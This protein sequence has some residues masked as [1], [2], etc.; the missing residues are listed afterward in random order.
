[1]QIGEQ[2]FRNELFGIDLLERY[3]RDLARRHQVGARKGPERLLS[4][5]ADNEKVLREYNEQ[6]LRVEKKRSLTPAAEW[7]LDNSYLIEEQIHM[8]RRHLP[9]GFSRE[10][11]H[12]LYGPSVNRPRVHDLMIELISHVDA[13]VD[14]PHLTS[15][16]AAYQQLTQLKLGELWAIPIMLRLALIENLRRVAVL[17]STARTERDMADTWADRL[18]EVAESEPSKL[19]IVVA[20]M[21]QSELSLSQ[22]FVTEFWRRIQGKSPLLKPALGWIEQ[23]LAEDGQTI[24]HLIQSENQGQAADQVSVGNSIASLRFLDAMDWREFVETLSVVEQT[25]RLDP[26]DVYGDMD[27]ATRD[28]YR[29]TVER[30]ARSS[31]LSEFEV[32]KLAVDLA[33]P[34]MPQSDPRLGHVGYYLVD[35]GVCALERAA[36]MKVPLKSLL[37]RFMRG[38]PLAFYLGSVVAISAVVM[39]WP[40]D[41]L[42]QVGPPGWAVILSIALLAV[43]ASQVAI[44]LVNWFATLV[45]QPRLIPRLDFSDGIPAEHRTMVVVPTMLTHERDI[46]NLLEALEVR[47]L[48]NRDENVYFALLSDL[49]DAPQEHLPGDAELVRQAREGIEALNRK[50]ER[51][52]RNIFYLFHRPR[53]WNAKENIWMGHER[54]RGKLAEFN[55]CLRGGP[56][57]CFCETIGDLSRLPHIRYVITLDTDTQLPRDAARDLVGSMAHPLNRPVYDPARGR[58]VDGYSILQPRV[59]VSLP[60]ASRSR[61]AKLFSGEPGVDPYTRGV[62]DVYQDL[63]HE[64]SFIGKGIYDV[65][66]FEQAVGGRF[67]ENRI[68]S[69]DLLEGSYARSALVTDVQLFEE[70]PGRYTADMHRRHRWMRGDWQIA[71]WLLPRVPGPDAR[72]VANPITGLSRW[73]IFDNLRR[74]L[75]PIA[76]TGLFLLGWTVLSQGAFAWT[77]LIASMVFV[78]GLLSLIAEFA[79][80]P[81]EL[82]LHMHLI[83]VAH[84]GARQAGQ[85][86]LTLVFLPYDACMSLDAAARTLFRLLFTRRHLLEWETA[87]ETE[88]R[89]GNGLESYLTTMWCAPALAVAMSGALLV[90]RPEQWLLALPLLVL[91]FFAPVVAWW[92]SV[93]I[94][95]KA[96]VLSPEQTAFLRK[97]AR[98]TWRY[99]EIFVGP[100]EHWLPPDNFQEN[101]RPLVATRTSPTNIGMGLLG[102]LAAWDFGYISLSQLIHRTRMTLQ[103]MEKMKRYRGHFYNWYDTRTLKA[104]PP[105]YV[106]T[107]DNG[108][109]AGLLLTL[110]SGLLDLAQKPWPG[111][112]SFLGLRDTLQG[113]VDAERNAA[114][115]FDPEMTRKLEW[116]AQ[117]LSEP[118]AGHLERI[119]L[120]QDAGK[121]AEALTAIPDIQPDHELQWWCKTFAEN[122][123]SHLDDLE[124]ALPW[125]RLDERV[126]TLAGEHPQFGQHLRKLWQDA[127]SDLDGRLSQN[128]SLSQREDRGEVPPGLRISVSAQ[129]VRSPGFV[130]LLIERADGLLSAAKNADDKGEMV[131]LLGE[132]KSAFEL[133]DENARQRTSTLEELARQCDDFAQMDFTILYD[134]SRELFSI[135]YNATHHRLDSSYYDLLA[136]EARLASFVAIA[137]GQ[138]PQQH[139]F[140]LGRLL[141]AV[142]GRPSLIS[143]SGSMFE[144][145]MPALIMPNYEQTLLDVSCQAAV[146]RQID[147]G[148][149]LSLP[150]GISESGY[151]LRDGLANYQYRAFGVPGLGFKRGLADD[152][153]IAPY[154]TAMALMVKPGEACRNLERL[155]DEG[156]EGSYGF[157][158]AIDYTPGRVPPRQKHAIV[159]SFMAHHQGMTLLALAHRLLDQPMQRRFQANPFF[160]AAELLLQERVPRNTS[161]LYPHELEAARGREPRPATE[162]AFRVFTNPNMSA[163]EVQLLSNGRYHV[164]ISSAGG[165]YSLWNETALTR[166]REDPTRDCWGAF[167]YLRDLDSREFWSAA[168]QPTLQADS[169]YEAIFSQGRAEF[170]LRLHE[171][172]AHT[173]ISVSPEDDIEVRRITLTNRSNEPRTIE[174]T[175]FAEVA[176][177]PPAADLAHPAFNKLFIQTQ[178]LRPRH[179]VLCSRRPRSRSELAPWMFQVMLIQG[180]EVGKASFETDRSAFLGRGGDAA[181]PLALRA[182][183]PLPN[184]QGSVLDPA[185]AIRRTVSLAPKQSAGVS[186]ISGIAPTREAAVALVEKYQDQLIADRVFELAW[187]HGLVTLRHLDTSESQAQL[188]GRL[189]GALFYSQPVRRAPPSVLLQNRRGQRSLWSFGISGDL[190]I[191]LVRSTSAERID[192]V[193]EVLQAHAYWR[194][195]GVAVD[196]VILHEDDSIYRQLVHEQIM[197]LIASGMEAQM[198]DKPG[199]VFVRRA[200][201]LSNEDHVLLQTAARIV[202]LDDNGTLFEQLQRRARLE[203]VHPPLV[204]TRTGAAVI[205][206][207]ETPKRELLFFNGLGGFTPDGRE[208]VIT[209]PPNQATPAPWVNVLGNP[210]FGT[211][212]SESG[213]SYTWLENCHEFRLTPWHNDPVTDLSGE[214]LYIRD[215]QTGKFWSPSPWP[216]CGQTPYVVRHGFG[217]SVFEHSEDGIASELWIFVAMDAPMKFARLILRNLS[218]RSRSLSLFGYWEWVLGEQRQKS[219][220]H[221]VTELDSRSGALLARNAYNVDFEE[222]TAFVT[223]SEPPRSRTGDRAEFLGRNNTLA[224]PAALGRVRLSGRVGAG[225][226][227]CAALQVVADLAPEEEREIVFRL[228][229]GRDVEKTRHLIQIFRS[230]ESCRDALHLVRAHW[231][232]TLRAV[233]VETPDAA[234][235]VLA[236]GWLLYQTLSC[237]M[238]AR[239]GFYQSGGAFGF[240]DQLQ[241]AMALIHSR[242][243]LLREHLLR[244]A[245]HQFREGD[246]QHWWHPPT[247]RGVRTHFSDD[248]LWLPYAACRYVRALGDT[249][250]LDENV[251]FLEGRPVKAEEEG[252]YDK[253]RR[254]NESGSL[255]EHC[256]RAIRYGLK[257]GQHGLPLIGC[258]DWNDGLNL[259]GEHGKGESVWLAFFLADVLKQF[260]SVARTRGDSAFAKHCDE[261]AAQLRDNIDRNAWDGQWYRRAYFDNGEPL[262]SAKNLECQIDALPQSWAVLARASDPKRT[263]TAMESLLQ[264]LVRH[265][266]KLIQL[267]DPPFDKSPLDPGYI[268]GYAPG[269]RENG[270]Q[271]THAAVWTVMAV[272]LM[273]DFPRAWELFQMINPIRHGDTPAKISRY[274]VEPYV[275][276]ADVYS[277]PPHAGR[278]GWTWYTGSAGWMYRLILETFLGLELEVNKLRITPRIPP[279]WKSFKIHYR[280]RETLHHISVVNVSGRWRG[281]PTVVFDGEEQAEPAIRLLDDRK[282]HTIEVRFL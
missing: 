255:Y 158:E 115:S 144:Y 168:Y 34:Q 247:D 205:T 140:A 248:Y 147:Y 7:L 268:K 263:F 6:T 114:V 153:V 137:L 39:L 96:L 76:L 152:M 274:K 233:H 167:I 87:S 203:T 266:A 48:A 198:L 156:A 16:V 155:R 81:E 14:A 280:Y 47:Y 80:K 139:W 100:E 231:E 212:V 206:P 240:R 103:T 163:P 208:Y 71:T 101:P 230:A 181:R 90:R 148:R 151:H 67:P 250:V 146:T 187:T 159:R 236:N 50:Y 15:F 78:P 133:A 134:F 217:Y 86:L 126:Q 41:L 265:D 130:Q 215:D 246:V 61:F 24:E 225:Y 162:A 149:Q 216:A 279:D 177:S 64:G 199:G 179:A 32:A 253:P 110:R 141:T 184:N 239:S 211:I 118:P 117:R 5:L 235:N 278:G 57:D 121:L 40:L 4:R 213:S 251:P 107:V 51:D 29:H 127:T 173:E 28:A 222:R 281:V 65:D 135:G 272:A 183:G 282:E 116:L 194:L 157:Y 242:P 12:L 74:S 234:L 68:L 160:K 195:K 88:K 58:V 245:A 53:R 145:L 189:A 170:R 269:V 190:P 82:G 23:R 241:D 129:F 59:A 229:A 120:L 108:N 273:G 111:A 99:F 9:R 258:G 171:I 8:A 98:K 207:Q 210:T 10:L 3:A 201:Q 70:F 35:R 19:I 237:R 93:P 221:V 77:V 38:M 95:D 132:V 191:V 21:A 138:L 66:A 209:L 142:D 102:T 243:G 79:R 262:G 143:W 257:F 186:L 256:V 11:P 84:A 261:Q 104:L 218:G 204:G 192:L 89:G 72:R 17:L 42:Q 219:L 232:D 276:A 244:A 69:H 165:G 49:C 27:F 131:A 154:A 175:S 36:R 44:S 172:D 277:V 106:S 254:S 43:S 52:R 249:G 105:F 200:D 94:G 26:A 185:I 252:Y 164:M 214:A 174:V 75:V 109:L 20:E 63:F 169:N 60:S 91:W 1:M 238:W 178:I 62:S 150:W 182:T 197:A 2:P 202:L 113:L 119:R 37:P 220:M 166:W 124:T 196:L 85:A 112:M 176:L 267:F 92:V 46:E 30:I 25:L 123:R 180:D 226:D 56:R 259:V 73:K 122:C 264:R 54:K 83:N 125:L 136:S 97:L 31:P 45:I 193:R 22:A 271:Y 33:R 128:F 224:N 223:V 227:P 270:G 275:V 161:V 228:G 260:S 188:F 13:R 18:L 55:R